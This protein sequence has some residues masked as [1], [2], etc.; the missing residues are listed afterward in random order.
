[1]KIQNSLPP[2]MTGGAPRTERRG[3]G[4]NKAAD[5]VSSETV[6]LSPAASQL[7]S[8]SRASDSFDAEK[9]ERIRQA[10]A[11]GQMHIRADVI[12]DRMLAEARAQQRA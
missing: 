11:N 6:T 2:V 9:V 7:A 10:I 8:A 1:M 12:A 3:G 5:S 4:N